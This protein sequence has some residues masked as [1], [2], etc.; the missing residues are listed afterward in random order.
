MLL[1]VNQM[2]TARFEHMNFGLIRYCLHSNET[3]A[4]ICS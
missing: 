1:A 4:V 2:S 3:F